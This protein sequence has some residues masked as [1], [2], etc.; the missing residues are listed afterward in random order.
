MLCQDDRLVA[1]LQIVAE[2]RYDT[3]LCEEYKTVLPDEDL[4]QL[5]NNVYLDHEVF[6]H[7]SQ[8]VENIRSKLVE[9]VH[10]GCAKI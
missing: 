3:E 10:Y 2:I 1:W 6:K 5:R 9:G 4:F 7:A 8:M